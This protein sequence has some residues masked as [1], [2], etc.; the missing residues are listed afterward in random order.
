MEKNVHKLREKDTATFHSPSE[1]WSLPAQSSTKPEERQFVADS[2]NSVH[3][4]SKKYLNAAELETIRVSRDPTT[5]ITTSDEMQTNG[6]T[7]VYVHDLGLFVTVQIR[8]DT[9]AVL[10]L[11]KLCEDHGYA[12]SWFSGQKPHLLQKRQENTMQH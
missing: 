10:S 9:P 12:C 1:I 4:L 7:T 6:E 11:G 2:R 5:D 3:M 8:E